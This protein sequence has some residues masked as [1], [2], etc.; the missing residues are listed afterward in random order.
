MRQIVLANG[1]TYDCEWC[2]DKSADTLTMNL[3]TSASVSALALAFDNPDNTEHIELRGGEQTQAFD[4]YTR[5]RTLAVGSWKPGTILIIM[6][7]DVDNG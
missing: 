1:Q 6:G 5:L 3:S 4:G 2:S 7:K